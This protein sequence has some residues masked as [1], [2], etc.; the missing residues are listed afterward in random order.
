MAKPISSRP[1]GILWL[2]A[3][4]ISLCGCDSPQPRQRANAEYLSAI[5]SWQQKRL[6]SLKSPTGWLNLAGLFWL[7]AGENTVGADSA[8]A[9]IF[10]KGR[11]PD[12]LGSFILQDS[13]V[14]FQ[15]RP[16]VTVTH[17]DSA[18]TSIVMR[19][20]QQKNPTQLALGSL[21]WTIIK[22]GE[23]L[24]V[25][26]R[27]HQHPQL[28][29]FAGIETFPVDST[30]RLEA[31]F[32]ANHPPKLIAIPTVLNTI[33]EEP[34]PGT[35]VFKLNGK[36]HRLDATGKMTDSELFVIFADQTNGRE[37]YG[38][39][40]FLYVPT[41]D[42]RGKSIIDFNKAHNPPCAFTEFATC[43]LPPE[44]NKLPVRITAGEKIY[45]Y[46]MH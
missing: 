30:W 10:P 33:N 46:A 43:P 14:T 41:P 7:K 40:R 5:Q 24:G 28:Q 37:T 9:I 45:A 27:D 38:A 4:L 34:S 2:V 36:T 31:E 13:V 11:A 6:T 1:K 35:F 16:G 3:G 42:A 19:T 8:N 21:S 17:H 20:D 32:E 26:L 22:R 39:G 25:R 29:Q 18:V 23:R 12:F 44:Q 15:A